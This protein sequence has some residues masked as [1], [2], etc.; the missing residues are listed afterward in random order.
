[1]SKIKPFL[2]HINE[3]DERD[4]KYSRLKKLGLTQNDEPEDTVSALREAFDGDSQL[5]VLFNQVD[6]RVQELFGPIL[7]RAE[8]S[9]EDWEDIRQD[10]AWQ[11]A[12]DVANYYVY[13][14]ISEFGEGMYESE[15]HPERERN[16]ERLR[17]LGLAPKK[18]FD[19][20]WDDMMD[21]WDSDPEIEA[22][23]QTLKRKTNEIIDKHI[24]FDD[25][26]DQ[27]QWDQRGEW[28]FEQ[29]VDDLGFFEYM[30]ASG[31]L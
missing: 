29:R 22:A 7:E 28:F 16:I 4:E 1:M 10:M 21:E 2:N 19:E 13:N 25:N 6:A 5:T 31:S 24:D 18:E 14:A 20:R 9:S 27:E 26:D 17:G 8:E 11:W 3:S 12:E 30:V 23:I 15:E